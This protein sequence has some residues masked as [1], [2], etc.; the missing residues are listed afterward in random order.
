[1]YACIDLGSNSFHILI[2]EWINGRVKIIERCSEAV[3]L[4]EEVG[5]IGS[6]S[7]V[8]F[9]RGLDCLQHFKD[10]MDLY[11]LERYWALGTNTFRVTDNAE[12]FIQAAKRIGIEISAISGVQEAVL[13]YA[14]V[15]SCLPVSDNHRLVIDIGGGSTEVIVGFKH[16]RLLTES[17]AIGGVA[18]RDVFFSEHSQDLSKLEFQLDTA[19]E[20]SRRAFAEIAPGMNK[21]SCCETY[22]SSG[23]AKM[24]AAICRGHSFGNGKIGLQALLELKPTILSKIAT[25]ED[26]PGLKKRR[27][28]LLL[29]GWAVM[30]GLMQAYSLGSVSFS[31]SALREGMLDFMVRNKKTFAAMQSSNLPKV[32]FANN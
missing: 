22:A 12:I 8:A 11:P 18:W 1:M 7:S 19:T 9:Q 17:L 29:P 28:D 3:Q 26:L 32:S 16:T 5:S 2:G 20:A 23:T 15:T 13:I 21:V 30:V 10:L 14:G 4:G 24:L 25:G 27:R 6:I 31:A